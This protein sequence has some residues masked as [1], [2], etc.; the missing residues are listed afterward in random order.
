MLNLSKQLSTSKIEL[1]KISKSYSCSRMS[2]N[3]IIDCD[4]ADAYTSNIFSR[5]YQN[6]PTF[7]DTLCSL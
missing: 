4:T 1:H 7:L 3:L 5:V 6:L 2:Y